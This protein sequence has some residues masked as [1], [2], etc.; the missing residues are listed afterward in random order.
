MVFIAQQWLNLIETIQRLIEA[1]STQH[2]ALFTSIAASTQIV[3][4]LR[5][6]GNLSC[7]TKQG[8]RWHMYSREVKTISCTFRFF[9]RWIDVP[10]FVFQFARFFSSSL[11]WLPLLDHGN[12]SFP[13]LYRS[14]TSIFKM[15]LY[16]LTLFIVVCIARQW[17]TLIKRN[18]DLLSLS[19]L[20]T[21]RLVYCTCK[22]S[23]FI[24]F[25]IIS[26]RKLMK[27]KWVYYTSRYSCILL[28][29]AKPR[30]IKEVP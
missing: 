17:A 26:D 1:G 9:M 7:A 15:P 5:L 2:K 12:G 19:P 30:P 28:G 23:I 18:C 10:V 6:A 21:E 24:E 13:L 20:C 11:L 29:I 3:L 27:N 8:R 14:G 16:S 25:R 22:T 4:I